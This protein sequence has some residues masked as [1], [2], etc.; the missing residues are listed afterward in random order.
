MKSLMLDK[1]INSNYLNQRRPNFGRLYIFVRHDLH[2]RPPLVN[3]ILQQYPTLFHR[4]YV[5][6]Q[7]QIAS[8]STYRSPHLLQLS[9]IAS[10]FR[11]PK[12]SLTARTQINED[13]TQCILYSGNGEDAFRIG[14]DMLFRKSSIPCPWKKEKCGTAITTK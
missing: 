14:L 1:I 9:I 3:Q 10:T 11:G 5:L 2:K 8:F 13:F 6:P 7:T 12:G 4:E